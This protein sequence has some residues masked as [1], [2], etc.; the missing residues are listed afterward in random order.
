MTTI[1]KDQTVIDSQGRK[2]SLEIRT[3]GISFEVILLTEDAAPGLYRILQ[4]R[5]Y[6]TIAAANKSFNKIINQF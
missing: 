1:I 4:S 5:K 2:Y 6:T 3:S